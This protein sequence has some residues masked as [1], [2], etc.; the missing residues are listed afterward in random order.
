MGWERR[1]NQSYFYRKERT[2]GGIRS[3]YVGHGEFALLMAQLEAMKREGRKAQQ[4][5]R[6]QEWRGVAA[7]DQNIDRLAQLSNTL[8]EAVFLTAGFHQHKRQ[9]RKKRA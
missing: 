9:W 5:E 6:R 1:D 2:P 8:T 7:L 3:V 4:V